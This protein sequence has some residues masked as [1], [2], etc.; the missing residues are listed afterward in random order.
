MPELNLDVVYDLVTSHRIG[1]ERFAS[2]TVKKIAKLLAATNEDI[3]KAVSQIMGRYTRGYELD[4]TVLQRLKALQSHVKELISEAYGAVNKEL[5]TDLVQIAKH[6]AE[7]APFT[8][9]K[10]MQLGQQLAV[11]SA[12]LLEAIVTARPFQGRILRDWSRQMEQSAL[13]R[14]VQ[15][16]NIGMVEGEGIQQIKGRL[17]DN[18]LVANEKAAT[19]VTRTAVNHVTNRAHSAMA[20]ENPRLFPHYRW[21]S[22]LDMRTSAMCR[23]R[24][25]QVFDTGKGPLPP[26]HW[27]C[28]S[29]VVYIPR[30]T[31]AVTEHTYEEWLKKQPAEVQADILGPS[32][33][34]L[35]KSGKL[36]LD[37]FVNRA[38]EELTLDELKK[39][40]RA[41]WKRAG[42]E[43]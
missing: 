37:K 29:T 27:N 20:K 36:P 28:R 14:V 18:A 6:E 5:R 3:E 7:W 31:E 41:A 39:R 34:A 17:V 2:G 9:E 40:E 22:V 11:P 24:A 21:H 26:G 25:G 1:L 16:I 10:A 12:R 23:A 35:W 19:A 30:G 43:D 32:R 15:Q 38:G 42:L 4:T 33:F 8:Y 13:H